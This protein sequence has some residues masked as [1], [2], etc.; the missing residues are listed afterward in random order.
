MI[1]TNQRYQD[2][3]S[4]L[5]D[6]AAWRKREPKTE[7]QLPSSSTLSK[8]A[9]GQRTAPDVPKAEKTIEKAFR[10]AAEA[11]KLMEAADILEEAINAAPTLR[12]RYEGQIQ[13]WR[14]GIAM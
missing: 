9:L 2:A 11:G 1:D 14:K 8:I 5:S 4:M 7:K 3:N 12:E 6:L 10:L 13:L